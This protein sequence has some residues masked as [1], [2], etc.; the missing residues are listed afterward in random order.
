MISANYGALLQPVLVVSN[1]CQTIVK[2]WPEQREKKVDFFR[3]FYLEMA[4]VQDTPSARAPGK[5]SGV[6]TSKSLL[7]HLNPGIKGRL[8]RTPDQQKCSSS[9]CPFHRLNEGFFLFLEKKKLARNLS[10]VGETSRYC[11]LQPKKS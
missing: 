5:I 11:H 6:Q 3:V 7:F 4:M 10:I 9:S 2:V 1:E 8:M